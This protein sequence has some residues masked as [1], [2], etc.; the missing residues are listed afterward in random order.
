MRTPHLKR[1]AEPDYPI[2]TS[3]KTTWT[4]SGHKI[5]KMADIHIG[6]FWGVTFGFQELASKYVV[7][8][9]KT[10]VC[11]GLQFNRPDSR[12]PVTQPSC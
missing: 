9:Q 5:F 1:R 12:A 6:G 11:R 7:D 2:E 10:Q 8:L 4:I 3:S